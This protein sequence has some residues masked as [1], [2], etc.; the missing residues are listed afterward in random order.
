MN[1]LAKQL[2]ITAIPE[3]AELDLSMVKM[4]IMD[5]EEGLGWS[6]Q[7]CEK[8]EIE[9]KRFLTL[10]F[11]YP[12]EHIVPT[13]TMDKFWHFHILD[14]RKYYSDC[15]NIF[16]IFIHH[17]PYLGM[18]GKDDE[19]KLNTSFE[20]TKKLYKK[21]FGESIFDYSSSCNN[22]GGGRCGRCRSAK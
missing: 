3:I 13:K 7:E 20:R 6:F 10:I 16:G 5:K 8:A 18:F 19:Q 4:K 2:S 1:N 21:T 17:Y 22:G 9:Y 12:K 14:T 15:I 11:L